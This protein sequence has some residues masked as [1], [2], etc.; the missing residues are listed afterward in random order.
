MG[1]LVDGYILETMASV[2]QT[3]GGLMGVSGRGKPVW[4][5]VTV[6][7][8]DGTKLRSGE[9][10][11]DLLPLLK[12]Y[13]PDAVLVNCSPPEVVGAALLSLKEADI[14]L[15][16]YANGFVKI[17]SS[18]NSTAVTVDLLETRQDLSPAAYLTHAREWAALGATLIGGCCEI[19]PAHIRALAEDF[20]VAA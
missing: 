8:E 4:L 6:S 12:E 14:T 15:G 13:K 18:F 20:K 2:D 7:D 16:A 9:P 17:A 11:S 10:V 1:D 5:G 19:G 3:R